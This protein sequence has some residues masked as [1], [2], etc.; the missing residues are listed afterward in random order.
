MVIRRVAVTETPRAMPDAQRGAVVSA[1]RRL[2]VPTENTALIWG[3]VLIFV[4]L[5]LLEENWVKPTQS[6]PNHVPNRS[7][8]TLV[9]LGEYSIRSS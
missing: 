2:I 7:F 5:A 6:A 8:N 3:P 9:F 4:L 1:Q